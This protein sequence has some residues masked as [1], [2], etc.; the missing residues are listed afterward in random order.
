MKENCFFQ[1]SRSNQIVH[2]PRA[3]CTKDGTKDRYRTLIIPIE[4]VDAAEDLLWPGNRTPTIARSAGTT[5]CDAI[6]FSGDLN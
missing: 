3:D 1:H 5:S 4:I 6:E 2:V